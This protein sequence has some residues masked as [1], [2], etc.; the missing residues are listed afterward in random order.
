MVRAAVVNH[1]SEWPFGGYGEIQE[2]R[3]RY[4]LIDH[5]GLRHLLGMNSHDQLKDAHR[6]WVEEA[7]SKTNGRER[8]WTESI[9]VGSR[10]FVEET[11][12]RL[13]S[14]ASRRTPRKANGVYELREPHS[15]YGAGFTPQNEVLT[16][17]NTRFWNACPDKTEG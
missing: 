9:A 16:L 17:E 10:H 11:K 5:E 7:L 2:P 3:K 8:A 4:A 1:P 6:A 14:R 15:D 12:L 13:G